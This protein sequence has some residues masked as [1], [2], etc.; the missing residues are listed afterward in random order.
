MHTH[1][2]TCTHMC[3]LPA[4][5]V[6]A[7][8]AHLPLTLQAAAENQ[9]EFAVKEAELQAMRAES[10]AFQAAQKQEQEA[11]RRQMQGEV[12]GMWVACACG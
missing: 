7:G 2:P 9:R 3:L 10:A 4:H 12:G 5:N 1:A 11:L 6:T 8:T